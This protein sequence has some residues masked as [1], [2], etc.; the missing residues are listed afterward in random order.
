VKVGR[1]SVSLDP[2]ATT[3]QTML[4][5]KTEEEEINTALEIIQSQRIKELVIEKL[6]VDSVLNGSLPESG[7]AE[8]NKGSFAS[9]LSNTVDSVSDFL[10]RIGVRDPVSDT[11]RALI[12]LQD[13]LTFW[14]S[15]KS[16]VI[17]INATSRTPEMSQA[18]VATAIEAYVNEHMAISQTEGSFEFFRDEVGKTANDLESAKLEMAKFMS[19]RQIVSVANNEILLANSWDQIFENIIRL[20]NEEK[21]LASQFE[22]IHPRRVALIEELAAARKV[23]ERLKKRTKGVLPIPSSI[24]SSVV[25]KPAPATNRNNQVQLAQQ[26]TE[27]PT[28]YADMTARIES[29]ILANNELE[30]YQ[31]RVETLEIQLVLHRQKLEEARLIK[32]QKA[33]SISNITIFQEATLNRKPVA[34]NKPLIGLGT[35]FMGFCFAGSLG[36]LREYRVRSKYLCS[37]NDVERTLELPVLAKLSADRSADRTLTQKTGLQKMRKECSDIVH[38]FVQSYQNDSG[39]KGI[40]VGVLGFKEGDGA[41]TVAAALATSCS[42]DFGIKTLLIDADRKRQSVKRRFSLNG[43]PGLHELADEDST[44]QDCLQHSELFNLDM[45]SST[46]KSRFEKNL[47]ALSIAKVMNR[48]R[49]LR[50]QFDVVIVDLPSATATDSLVALAPM[51][52]HVLFVGESGK[53]AIEDAESLKRK[54]ANSDSSVLGVILNKCRGA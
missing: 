40:V 15:K 49:E 50:R 14:A 29:L 23:F 38:Q 18:I 13:D 34:P 31:E 46:S 6:G 33:N 36:L 26:Q 24:P 42:N 17:N 21:E 48:L 9:A 3:S 28:N 16:R 52:D 22:A 7:E 39:S 54:F 35:I 25:E 4:M 43:A 30:N 11:E 51:M 1:E 53:I 8:F 12:K 10:L 27:I 45:V 47:G 5:Q 20:E 2:T 19:E 44:V 41:S 32:E 37:Q